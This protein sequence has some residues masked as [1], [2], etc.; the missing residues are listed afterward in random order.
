MRKKR[1]PRKRQAL[2]LAEVVSL[3]DPNELRVRARDEYK[4][5]ICIDEFD[6]NREGRGE[7][8]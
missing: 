8:N 7:D 3:K 2:D 1:G 6:G 4:R 5:V